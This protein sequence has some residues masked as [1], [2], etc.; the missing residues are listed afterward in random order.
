MGG[1]GAEAAGA[2]AIAAASAR[3]ASLLRRRRRPSGADQHCKLRV[4]RGATNPVDQVNVDQSNH[5]RVSQLV[6]AFAYW[7]VREV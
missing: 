3:T 1:I 5:D 4:W 6:Q 7:A 2:D